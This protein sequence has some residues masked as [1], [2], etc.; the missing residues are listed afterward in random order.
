ML[1]RTGYVGCERICGGRQRRSE[2]KASPEADRQGTLGLR[3][4]TAEAAG[5]TAVGVMATTANAGTGQVGGG[6]GAGRAKTKT[7]AVESEVPVAAT[8]HCP[9]PV[10]CRSAKTSFPGRGPLRCAAWPF[11][12]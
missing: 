9:V 12:S 10:L 7:P 4:S 3:L 1:W 6:A 2:P 8:R 5:K 11:L